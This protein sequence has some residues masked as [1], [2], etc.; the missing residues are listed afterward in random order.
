[1]KK[2]ILSILIIALL[3]ISGFADVIPPHYHVVTRTVVIANTSQFPEVQLVGYITGPTISGFQI[4]QIKENVAL[5][6]GYKMNTYKLYAVKTSFIQSAGGLAA[7][8]FSAIAQR[9]APIDILDPGSYAIENTK[10]IASE[11]V[12][13]RIWGYNANGQ[14]VVYLAR[15]TITFSDGTAPQTTDYTYQP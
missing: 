3:T 15:K 12:V 2:I 14:L 9:V 5:V 10:P 8:N 4:D 11:N 7:I 1:M 13:Y 6:K